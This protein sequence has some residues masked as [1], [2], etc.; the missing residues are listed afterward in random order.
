MVLE[1]M[2]FYSFSIESKEYANTMKKLA[3]APNINVFRLARL[4]STAL[5]QEVC[6]ASGRGCHCALGFRYL[7][8]L[9]RGWPFEQCVFLRGL[10]GQRVLENA[11]RQTE[12]L[13]F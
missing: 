5:F 11:R 7:V 12:Y 6:I 13:W 9:R 2:V 1:I 8:L 4:R 10:I 3:Y